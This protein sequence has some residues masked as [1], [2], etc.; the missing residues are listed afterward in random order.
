MVAF[1]IRR[2]LQALLILLVVAVIVFLAV[3]AMGN[4]VDALLSPDSDQKERAA[5]IVRL[6]L[7]L[8]LYQ[9]FGVFLWNALHG[10]IGTSFVYGSSAMG[11]IMDRF[12]AT[13]ELALMALGLATIIG[14][15][16]GVLAGLKSNTT[17]GRSIM[18]GSIL[19]F[20]LPNFW[21]G[22]MLIL[23][24]AVYLRILPSGGRGETVSIAGI[25][26]SFLTLDGLR[27]LI[28]PALTLALYKVSLVIRI[29][30]AGT[31]E[32]MLQDY[33]RFARAKGVAPLRIV[34]THILKNVLIPVV[35]IM[36][37]ETGALI[38]FAVVVET[39]FAYPGMGKLLIDSVTRL[40]RPVI[41]S[42]L[43]VTTVVFVVL[44]LIVDLIYMALD[45]RVRL[46]DEGGA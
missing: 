15:P 20:S 2:I 35:T 33:V 5:A 36:G 39:V 16:L 45:P 9:Q 44:N 41:V 32:V 6:G 12:P 3:Y 19:G 31:R 28:L 14:I 26:F 7:D 34:C 46:T 8:P 17:L 37:M 42:Y 10:D 43:L 30:E 21:I 18:T 24:F 23:V 4:P 27:H 29:C 11:V 25:H 40:D 22:L 1:L 13:L 38:A